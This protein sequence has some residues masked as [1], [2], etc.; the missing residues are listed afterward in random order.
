[1]VQGH[2]RRTGGRHQ[3]PSAGRPGPSAHVGRARARQQPRR[4]SRHSR[5]RF[6]CEDVCPEL[7]EKER[8]TDYLV[9]ILGRTLAKNDLL[10]AL[11]L[12]DPIPWR[13]ISLSAIS[14]MTLAYLLSPPTSPLVAPDPPL[15]P[16]PGPIGA[17]LGAP[18]GI[19]LASRPTILDRRPK[20]LVNYNNTASARAVFMSPPGSATVPL[21]IATTTAAAA[22]GMEP[23]P[24][25]F[26]KER[27]TG[28]EGLDE[29]PPGTAGGSYAGGLEEGGAAASSG[30]SAPGAGV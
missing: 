7:A 24:L 19:P 17:A 10:H 1:M 13:H 11:D 8:A 25:V 28:V 16:A 26:D 23:S 15:L 30:W 29:T 14:Q 5:R 20:S 12:D 3:E 2:D 4:D 22:A 27:Y 6:P 18:S 21:R 9:A